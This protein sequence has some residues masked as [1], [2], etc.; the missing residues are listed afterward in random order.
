[1]YNPQITAGLS[2]DPL[3]Q[4]QQPFRDPTGPVAEC[5]VVDLVIGSLN[6]ARQHPQQLLG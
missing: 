5:Q 6:P 2:A 3:S 4:L 1:M